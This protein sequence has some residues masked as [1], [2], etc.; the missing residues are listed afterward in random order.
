MESEY[1]SFE[2]VLSDLIR[3]KDQFWCNHC[4]RGLFFPKACTV[5]IMYSRKK[6][7]VKIVEIG[8]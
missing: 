5:H 3:L 7:I 1:G 6:K 2:E 8:D 4:E